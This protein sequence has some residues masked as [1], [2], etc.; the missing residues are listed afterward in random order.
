M[1][2]DAEYPPLIMARG[3]VPTPLSPL[4]GSLAAP[5]HYNTGAKRVEGVV[6]VHIV[7]HSHDD[8]GARSARG[9]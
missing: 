3:G 4:S 1:S 2:F 9:V 5:S 6:N 7:V 8:V